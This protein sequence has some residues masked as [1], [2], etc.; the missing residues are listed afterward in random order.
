MDLYSTKDSTKAQHWAQRTTK[1]KHL[2]DV[3][4]LDWLRADRMDWQTD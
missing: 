3:T 2:V 4:E 1:E